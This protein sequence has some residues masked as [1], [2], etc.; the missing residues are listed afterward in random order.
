MPP[1][2]VHKCEGE[3]IAATELCL[4]SNIYSIKT[5]M[6]FLLTAEKNSSLIVILFKE[7]KKLPLTTVTVF[8]YL[9][10]MLLHITNSW[11]TKNMHVNRMRYTEVIPFSQSSQECKLRSR[12]GFI[13]QVNKV[14]VRVLGRNCWAIL[15]KILCYP[16]VVVWV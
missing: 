9:S 16:L 3:H 14:T 8:Q 13:N 12:L 5:F 11:A 15:K 2:D 1:R 6:L 7:L 4:Q 10:L